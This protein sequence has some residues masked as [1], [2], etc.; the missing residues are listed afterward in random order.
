MGTS[1]TNFNFIHFLQTCKNLHKTR[2]N[3]L[4]LKAAVS[5]VL[6][7]SFA[8]FLLLGTLKIV[9]VTSSPNDIYEN[10]KHDLKCSFKGWPLP[11]VMWYKAEEYEGVY[12][13]LIINGSG[14][15]SFSE[16]V[17]EEE[18][19]LTS[20]LHLPPGREQHEGSYTCTAENSI[21]GWS[22]KESFTISMIYQ[23]K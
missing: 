4:V 3:K 10:E 2:L 12:K 19:Q 20:I 23:C 16:K 8:L 21:P 9:Y 17:S 5:S 14:D 18:T 15:F 11:R 22:S 1:P 6:N 7:Y 13:E